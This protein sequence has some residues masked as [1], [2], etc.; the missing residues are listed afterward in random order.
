LRAV[1]SFPLPVLADLEDQQDQQDPSRLA[2]LVGQLDLEH[3]SVQVER[4]GIRG[5]SSVDLL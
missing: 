2:A 4:E 5:Y 3:R 1:Q